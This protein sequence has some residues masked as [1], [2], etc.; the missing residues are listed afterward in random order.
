MQRKFDNLN[1]QKSELQNIIDSQ[2]ARINDLLNSEKNAELLSKE[3]KRSIG[4]LQQRVTFDS[5]KLSDLQNAYADLSRQFYDYKMKHPEMYSPDGRKPAEDLADTN[6]LKLNL[7]YELSKTTPHNLLIYLIPDNP[8]NA[9][10]IRK[11]SVYE[12]GCDIGFLTIK[13]KN[14]AKYKDSLY[15]FYNV[16][17]GKYFVK[18]CSYYGGY[19]TVIKTSHGNV[20]VNFNASPPIR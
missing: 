9:K 13:N 8:S 17:P 4:Y 5:T 18:M 10:I 19:G 7:H 20:T 12:I 1:S 2:N 11:S 16:K 6:S 14:I 15:V 3:A